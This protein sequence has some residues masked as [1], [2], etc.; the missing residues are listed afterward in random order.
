MDSLRGLRAREAQEQEQEQYVAGALKF[1][2]E[3]HERLMRE[4]AQMDAVIKG[5]HVSAR[6]SRS[7]VSWFER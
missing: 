1:D 5:D 4:A 7:R 6:G 3:G 2:E